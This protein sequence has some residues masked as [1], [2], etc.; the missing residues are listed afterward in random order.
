MKKTSKAKMQE[1]LS[2]YKQLVDN[3]LH[4]FT[5]ERIIALLIDRREDDIDY[6]ASELS[7][8]IDYIKN[9]TNSYRS[10][11]DDA[12]SRLPHYRKEIKKHK[13]VIKQLMSLSKTIKKISTN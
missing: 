3:I 12:R 1:E 11:K 7:S 8:D 9:E 5:D 10:Q 2:T 13:D 4:K 6:L